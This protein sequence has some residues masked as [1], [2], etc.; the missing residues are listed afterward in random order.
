M[1]RS[2]RLENWKSYYEPVEFTM[3]AT[4]ERRHGDRLARVGRSRIL[5]VTAVY[6]AN[7]AGKSTLVDGLEALREI[8]LAA[9]RPG[10]PLPVTP[11]LLMGPREP[12][13]FSVELITPSPDGGED[14]LFLYKLTVD[15]R[16]VH[17]ESLVHVRRTTEEFLFERTGDEVV[18]CRELDTDERARAHATVVAPNET[19]LGALG[20]DGATMAAAAR[21]W[22]AL[23]LNIIHPGSRYMHL[24]AMIDTDAVFARA[25]SS[26]LTRADTGISEVTLQPM[27]TAALPLP[28]EQLDE[29]V[30]LLQEQGGSFV[31]SADGD[32][33]AILAL[34]DDGRPV[35]HR[36]VTVHEEETGPSPEERRSFT[37]PLKDESDG[38]QGFVNLLPM[39]FQLSAK[40]S[41]N[42]FIVDELENSMHPKLTEGFIASCLEDLGPEDRRQLIFTTHEIQLMR[43]DLLRRDEIWLAD[44]VGGQTELTRVSDFADIGVRKDADLL[45]FYMSGRLGG[46]PRV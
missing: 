40:D 4:R 21:N 6:G 34:D 5:P 33:Y 45:S 37:L 46:V 35:A 31:I 28:T 14:L 12:T 20:E 15:R 30:D 39:L 23:Q 22:F 36:L 8:I 10:A 3:V 25:M 24:Q 7:A 2:L 1:L 17:R 19:L 27:R 32:D 41:R 11:H 26:G 9:R 42:V 38:T 44:K 13:T 18:L 29:L 43:A 16:A